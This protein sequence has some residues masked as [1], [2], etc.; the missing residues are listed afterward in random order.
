M[1]C[2]YQGM[3]PENLE[4]RKKR[5]S[6]N[7]V[8]SLEKLRNIGIIAHIDAGK[9]TTT[10]RILY[11][12]GKIHRMGEVDQG[13]AQMDW[14]PQ[15]QERGITITSAATTCQWGLYTIN[16]IDT[17][18]H[19]DFTAEV[20][21][22]LRVLDGAVVVFCAVA[23]VQ[24]Q[25]EKVWRQAEKYQIPKI[26]FI[27]KMDRLGSD[28]DKVLQEMRSVLGASPLP[29]QAPVGT[30]TEFAG[31]VDLIRMKLLQWND[32]EGNNTQEI[33]IPDKIAPE[34]ERRRDS[35]LEQLSESDDRI[36]SAYLEGKEIPDELIVESVREGTIKGRFTPIFYGSSLK[37]KGVQP[38]LDAITGY[39]PS[40]LD[41]PSVSGYWNDEKVFREPDENAPFCGLVFKI[42][43]YAGR[44]TLFYVRVYSGSCPLGQKFLNG[45]TRT[46]ERVMKILRMHA[47]R[48]EEIREMKA[49]DIVALVGLK[50]ARTGDTIS[51]PADPVNLEETAFPEPVI[52]VSIEPKSAGDQEKLMSILGILAEE[53]PTFGVK[54]DEETGQII[55][56]GMGEL[57]L[58]VLTQRL[59]SE[60]KVEGRVGR[61]QVSYRETITEKIVWSEHFEREI[62]G[63]DHEASVTLQVEPLQG[64]GDVQFNDSL[65]ED[66]V[67]GDLLK[68]I[69]QTA[70][71][72]ARSG[73]KA[74]YPVIDVLITLID[75]KFYNERSTETA[76][77][78]ST[79]AALNHCL[80]EAGPV[81]L[82]PV[83]AV[84]VQTPEEFT[85]EVVGSLTLRRGT[86]E[87]VE[88]QGPLEAIKASVPLKEM[89][90]YTTCLRS[91]TQGRG[92]FNME[93]SSYR[94][95]DGE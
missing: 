49:G 8:M 55:L 89:F 93:L 73:A 37:R 26:V 28:P 83:M 23:G 78:A 13:S 72:G 74:G 52:F 45:R 19:V 94:Q 67:P 7:K 81:L 24:P 30:G 3:L 12:S 40:P 86:I 39:L 42:M 18:G 64:G 16:I 62:A 57:H 61:P 17:P 82:E 56:S 36:M 50:N 38:L 53:D 1:K 29:L 46:N 58:E 33:P 6:N 79:S 76:F 14:M 92:T 15:E 21:R 71:E 95:V 59:F 47:N 66:L 2:P 69:R 35:L 4:S 68:T 25:S 51:D 63:K 34:M 91:L 65:T 75:A 10:E 84:E 5:G 48:R 44:P 9:T 41:L 20:E 22:S 70:L 80:R 11:Y 60:F 88:K 77:R 43:A 54:V 27:N 85:G 87:G 90:G 32:P 31:V